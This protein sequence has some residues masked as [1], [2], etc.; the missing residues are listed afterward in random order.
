MLDTTGDEERHAPDKLLEQEGRI[1]A[2]C[3]VAPH[4]QDGVADHKV[5]DLGWPS[6]LADQVHDAGP[7]VD[8]TS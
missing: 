2:S 5:V 3:S 6:G 4:E 8:Q 7:R 1:L